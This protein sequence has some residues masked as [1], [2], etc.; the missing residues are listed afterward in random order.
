MEKGVAEDWRSLRFLKE[1][2]LIYSLIDQ[3]LKKAFVIFAKIQANF[4]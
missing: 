4:T 3:K 1:M 2:R